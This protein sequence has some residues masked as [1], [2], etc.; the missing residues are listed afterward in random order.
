MRGD[1]PNISFDF[2]GF[3]FRARKTIWN[4]KAAHGFM[5]AAE[6]VDGH[7]RDRSAIAAISPLE[8]AEMYNPCIP[9]HHILQPPATSQSASTLGGLY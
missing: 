6:S 5:P 7:R 4:G 3:Q 1:F 9:R 8:L 2:L